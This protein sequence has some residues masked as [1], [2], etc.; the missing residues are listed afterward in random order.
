MSNQIPGIAINNGNEDY[1]RG[2]KDGKKAAATEW[3]GRAQ[4]LVDVLELIER[5][6]AGINDTITNDILTIARTELAKYKEVNK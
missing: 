5:K 3:A 2:Y 4:G 6:L 1:I